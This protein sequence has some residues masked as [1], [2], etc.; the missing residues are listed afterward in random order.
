MPDPYTPNEYADISI[1]DC[2]KGALALHHRNRFPSRE[3]SPDHRVFI[4]VHNSYMQ[5]EISGA[6]HRLGR[7]KHDEEDV[8]TLVREDPSTRTS[9]ISRSTVHRLFDRHSPHAC[10]VQ[11][12]QALFLKTSRLVCHF[13]ELQRC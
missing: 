12:V 5:G 13:V 9:E 2:V 7:P 6:T 4:R 3:R 10:H 8:L 1:M 11:G